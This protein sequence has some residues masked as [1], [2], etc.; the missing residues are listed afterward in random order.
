VG[1]RRLKVACDDIESGLVKL[2]TLA[3]ELHFKTCYGCGLSDYSP[4]GQD[5]FGTLM[6]FRD[7]NDDYRRVQTKWDLFALSPRVTEAVQETHV[8]AEWERRK[9]GTGYRG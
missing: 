4:G 2:Q 5:L 9:P 1:D 7:A 8:C 3:P 6:C